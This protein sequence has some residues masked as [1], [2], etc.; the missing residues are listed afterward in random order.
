MAERI[1]PYPDQQSS[2]S[3]PVFVPRVGAFEAILRHW[4]LAI[5]PVIVMVAAGIAL[6]LARDPVY[7][8]ETR[9]TVGGI[10]VSQPGALSGLAIAGETLA[11]TFSRAID[12]EAVVAPAGRAVGRSPDDVRR[13]VSANP[14]PESAVFRIQA[15]GTSAREAERLA[16][17]AATSLEAYVASLSKPGA[18]SEQVFTEFRRA[19]VEYQAALAAKDLAERRLGP[20]PSDAARANVTR[21]RGEADAALLRVEGLRENYLKSLNARN[22]APGVQQLTRAVGATSDQGSKLQLTLFAGLL[23]GLIAGVALATLRANRLVRRR[24]AE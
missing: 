14:V 17:A 4:P 2:G 9:M 6:G 22:A 10:D 18:R 3:I 5:L 20:D 21:L 19:S 23:A 16:N 1:A 24:L 15:T 13:R 7:T 12:A 11:Q 8:A